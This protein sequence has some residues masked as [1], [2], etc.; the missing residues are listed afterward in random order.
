[1]HLSKTIEILNQR[2]FY[3]ALIGDPKQDLRGR[4]AFRE[5]IKSYSENVTFNSDN[6]RCPISH[7]NLTNQF[8]GLKE[9]QIPRSNLQGILKYLYETDIEIENIISKDIFDYVYI[10]RKNDKFITNITDVNVHLKNLSHELNQILLNSHLKD[11]KKLN[12]LSYHAQQIC[13]ES[14]NMENSMIFRKIEKYLGLKLTKSNMNNLRV[15]LESNRKNESFSGIK[16]NSIDSVK[17]LEGNRC[18]FIVT[19]DIVPYLLGEN[20]TLNKTKNYLYVALTRAREEL[21]FLITKEVEDK[22]GRDLF[23]EKFASLNI[24]LIMKLE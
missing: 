15:A 18:M 7:V 5:L 22:Y 12:L 14:I 20:V 10:S 13:I 21:T 17:G 11:D 24:D 1:M 4:N 8:V 19:T 9:R 6:H 23:S 3:V 2:S 16:V